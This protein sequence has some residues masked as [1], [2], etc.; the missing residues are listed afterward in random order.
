[1]HPVEYAESDVHTMLNVA[2]T[3]STYPVARCKL[4]N[5]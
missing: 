5:A 4:Y 3:C 1:M 2:K